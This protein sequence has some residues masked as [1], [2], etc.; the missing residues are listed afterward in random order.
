[1][2]NILWGLRSLKLKREREAKGK[3]LLG[4]SLFLTKVGLGWVG[5]DGPDYSD[6][7]R[8]LLFF[9]WFGICNEKEEEMRTEK[10]NNVMAGI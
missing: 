9:F 5:L 3:E 7:L 10:K 1:M 4:F 8:V 2:Y 6:S